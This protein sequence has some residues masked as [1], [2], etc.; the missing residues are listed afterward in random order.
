MTRRKP[1]ALTFTVGMVLA[2]APAFAST[3]D[4]ITTAGDADATLTG[5]TV[6]GTVYTQWQR[7][8]LTGWTGGTASDVYLYNTDNTVPADGQR[9]A[10]LTGD[11]KL[12]TGLVNVP[13]L[14]LTFAAPVANGIGGEIVFFDLT[15]TNNATDDTT[16]VTINGVTKTA[17]ELGW[18]TGLVSS[19]VVDLPRAA[20]IL[21][22]IDDLTEL[23]TIASVVD[24]S[25]DRLFNVAGLAIDLTDFGVADGATITSL[26]L[27]GQSSL[28]PGFVGAL[29]IPEPASLAWLGIAGLMGLRRRG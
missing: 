29:I 23:E 16:T 2:A 4:S 6:D 27:N 12:L 20:S 1:L 21:E 9:A 11:D 19:A 10:Q 8:T 13:A 22:T 26:T 28:D 25:P 15:G 7:P 5:I 14:T 18:T 17:A 3:I 24:F